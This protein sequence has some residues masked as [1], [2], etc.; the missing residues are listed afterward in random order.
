MQGN[1]SVDT[2]KL[3]NIK[4]SLQQFDLSMQ[5]NSAGLLSYLAEKK[6]EVETNLN[7]RLKQFE[8]NELYRRQ[9]EYNAD[10]E[11]KAD[12]LAENSL[13]RQRETEELNDLKFLIKTFASVSSELEHHLKTLTGT[14]SETV[15]KGASTLEKSIQILQ[16]YLAITLPGSCSV[17]VEQG[18]AGGRSSSGHPSPPA[19]QIRT[20]ARNWAE[21]LSDSQRDAI[22]DYTKEVPPYYKNINGVLRGH[23]SNYDAGNEERSELI[24]QALSSARIPCDITV[25]RGCN[26]DVLG[27]LAFAPDE[28][29]TDGVFV[30]RGYVSTSMSRGLAFGGDLLLEIHLPAGTHA[31]NIESLSAAGRY[32][33][34]VLIDRGQMF[35]IVGAHKDGAGRR[36]VEVNAII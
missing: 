22:Y 36:I 2:Q 29:L 15:A 20:Y 12:V 26:S 5:S 17:A 14:C 6:S 27:D 23:K 21:N 8:V 4:T 13:Q 1:V 3:Q 9:A 33:E 25:Y 32:E 11:S 10:D 34:E 16:E 35:H 19:S 24:H 28:A 30:D 18:K 7:K 31:A